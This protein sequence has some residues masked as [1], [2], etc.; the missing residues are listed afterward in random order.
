M[1][2]IMRVQ[3]SAAKTMLSLWQEHSLPV[4]IRVSEVKPESEM[5]TVCIDYQEEDELLVNWLEARAMAVW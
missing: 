3:H 1:K 2:C 4:D 5:V